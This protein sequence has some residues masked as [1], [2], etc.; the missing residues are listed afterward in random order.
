MTAERATLT[1]QHSLV[2]QG[3]AE[4]VPVADGHPMRELADARKHLAERQQATDGQHI[5]DRPQAQQPVE[6]IQA[7]RGAGRAHQHQAPH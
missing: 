6:S 4:L 2:G 1:T 7:V 5:A 3:G